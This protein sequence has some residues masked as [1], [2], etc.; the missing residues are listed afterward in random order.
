MQSPSYTDPIFR[1]C[2]EGLYGL[3][4]GGYDSPSRV[5]GIIAAFMLLLSVLLP[6]LI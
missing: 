6:F 3:L 5:A 4:G 2:P 1:D